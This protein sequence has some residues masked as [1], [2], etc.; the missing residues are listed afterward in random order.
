MAA[1]SRDWTV[2]NVNP[3]LISLNFNGYWRAPFFSRVLVDRPDGDSRPVQWV[4]VAMPLLYLLWPK[5]AIELQ[6]NLRRASL[7]ATVAEYAGRKDL[8][9]AGRNRSLLSE[10]RSRPAGPRGFRETGAAECSPP[11]GRYHAQS[12]RLASPRSFRGARSRPHRG[13][14]RTPEPIGCAGRACGV[15]PQLPGA[16]SE[17]RGSRRPVPPREPADPIR[18]SRRR[19]S[20]ASARPAPSFPA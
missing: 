2:P 9:A 18:C 15:H 3:S 17:G 14:Y 4:P 1:N 5:D 19:W 10:G 20:P 8:F 7:E 13:S 16:R 12:G 6:L 11:C